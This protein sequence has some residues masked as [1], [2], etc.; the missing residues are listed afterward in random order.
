VGKSSSQNGRWKICIFWFPVIVYSG[1]IFYVSS[2]ARV[3]IPFQGASLDK[4]IHVF[5]YIPY[6]YLTARA[7]LLSRANRSTKGLIVLAGALSL[8]YGLSDEYHQSFVGGRSSSFLDVFAD[9][10]GGVIGGWF[11]IYPN[12]TGLRNHN[13]II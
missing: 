13:N 5:E 7:L 2:L 6:G 9:T 1:I 10:L 12:A 3:K 11:F 8:M 4:F